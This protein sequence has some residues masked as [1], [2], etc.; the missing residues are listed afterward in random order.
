V[1]F[2]VISEQVL[3]LLLGETKR[4]RFKGKLLTLGKQSSRISAEYLNKRAVTYGVSL[5]SDSDFPPTIATSGGGDDC[6]DD[7]SILKALGASSVTSL[8]FSD[9][10]GADVIYDLNRRELPEHFKHAFDIIIDIGVIEHVFDIAAAFENIHNILA[11]GG[12]FIIFTTCIHYIDRAFYMMSPTL[13]YDY[14]QANNYEINVIKLY[15]F[16]HGYCHNCL[17]DKVIDYV[18]GSMDFQPFGV[19]GRLYD[20]FCSVTKTSKST[21]DQIP[22]QR[23]YSEMWRKNGGSG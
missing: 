14:Y 2:F 19:D 21:F 5:A 9:Y 7:V 12:R 16:P 8:D 11:V 13:F 1:R 3:E 17:A 23:F 6:L 4:E 10:E 15:G 22:H 20:V 18:P